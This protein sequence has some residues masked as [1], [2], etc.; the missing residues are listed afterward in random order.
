[1]KLKNDSSI[2]IMQLVNI[3]G[4]DVSGV[5]YNADHNEVV[6]HIVTKGSQYYWTLPREFLGNKV[7]I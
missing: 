4:S 3:N 2:P 6:A 5:T 1:M 7:Q